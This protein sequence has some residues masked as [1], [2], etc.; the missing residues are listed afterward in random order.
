MRVTAAPQPANSATMEPRFATS[1]A[2]IMKRGPAHAV[3]LADQ[4]GQALACGQSQPRPHFLSE[5]EDDLAGQQH[6]EQVVA[7][8]GSRHRVGGDSTGVVVGKTADETRS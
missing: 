7:E 5:V 3:L 8:S 1:I 4:P 6:P 2:V